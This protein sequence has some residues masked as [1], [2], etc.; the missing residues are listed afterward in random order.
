VLEASALDPR[1]G[2]RTTAR[3]MAT[4]LRLIWRVAGTAS[5]MK[6]RAPS[7]AARLGGCQHD[8]ARG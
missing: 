1:R 2:I 4:L 5:L 7:G 8:D 3:E 6:V